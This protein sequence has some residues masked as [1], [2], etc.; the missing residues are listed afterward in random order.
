MPVVEL[1]F[2]QI[3]QQEHAPGKRVGLEAVREVQIC[4]IWI[5]RIIDRQ[6]IA[7]GKPLAG[8]VMGQHGQA[9]LL[10]VV[11]TTAPAGRFPGRLNGRQQ[12]AHERADNGDDDEQFDEGKPAGKPARSKA[13]SKARSNIGSQARSE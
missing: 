8:I 12:Q 10:E 4:R 13:R 5:E 11:L 7:G 9:N 6:R 1:G 3:R 2:L